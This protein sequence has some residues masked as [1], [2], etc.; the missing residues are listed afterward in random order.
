VKHYEGSN[1][2]VHISRINY[3]KG[4]VYFT[5]L[6]EDKWTIDFKID[7]LISDFGF[8]FFED[9]KVHIRTCL[10]VVRIVYRG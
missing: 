2:P 5:S 6:D 8:F 10:C 3:R 7:T 4:D 9:V 1:V